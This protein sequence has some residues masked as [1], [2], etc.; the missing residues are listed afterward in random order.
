MDRLY[1]IV[2]CDIVDYCSRQTRFY[3]VRLCRTWLFFVDMAV[4][5]VMNKKEL[6]CFK[7]AGVGV[8]YQITGPKEVVLKRFGIEKGM[9][10][11]GMKRRL[12]IVLMVREDSID[13]R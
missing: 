3:F 4:T 12:N 7:I 13:Q 2:A 5:V 10:S 8:D 1:W 6:S 9:K 11:E